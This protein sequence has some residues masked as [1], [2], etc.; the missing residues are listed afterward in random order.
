[1]EIASTHV[2]ET[3]T[4]STEPKAAYASPT[5]VVLGSVAGL[6]A[7]GLSSGIENAGHP[8]RRQ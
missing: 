3:S 1:M 7:T 4:T 6:T 5:L 2:S 8:E